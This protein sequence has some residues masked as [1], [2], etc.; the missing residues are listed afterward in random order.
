MCILYNIR[1]PK[2][3]E[4]RNPNNNIVQIRSTF[5]DLIGD[6]SKFQK[7]SF[8]KSIEVKSQG[9]DSDGPIIIS[10][11]N[12]KGISITYD[13]F[14]EVF[15]NILKKVDMYS[16]QGEAHFV[17]QIIFKKNVP[18]NP[19]YNIFTHRNNE[20]VK[21]EEY[22]PHQINSTEKRLPRIQKSIKNNMST[23]RN[24][25]LKATLL[26][27]HDTLI[28][29]ETNKKPLLRFEDLEPLDTSGSLFGTLFPN[30][31]KI[32]SAAD[33]QGHHIGAQGHW[34][35]CDPKCNFFI[36]LANMIFDQATQTIDCPIESC[37]NY[38]HC[39]PF[40]NKMHDIQATYNT[41]DVFKLSNYVC[42]KK[43]YKVCCSSP[44]KSL[45]RTKETVTTPTVIA[46]STFSVEYLDT[47]RPIVLTLNESKIIDTQL[48][49]D[50]RWLPSPKNLE[51]S[52][53]IS[54]QTGFIVGGKQTRIGEF[55][56]T[57]P[58][59]IGNITQ[60]FKIENGN[61][62]RHDQWSFDT[63]LTVGNDIALIRLPQTV[64]TF[65][66]NI[67]MLLQVGG[68]QL[69]IRKKTNTDYAKYGVSQSR[70]IQTNVQFIPKS[71]CRDFRV[72]K[73][74]SDNHICFNGYENSDS[75]EGDSGG[76]VIKLLES[77]MIVQAIVS[78]GTDKCG[79]GIPGNKHENLNNY[80]LKNTFKLCITKL[81]EELIGSKATS[82]A[83][84]FISI[85]SALFNIGGRIW[86]PL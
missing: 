41:K 52:R 76:G 23:I 64:E 58:L 73:S 67:N 13:P 53:D 40:V 74:I 9:N 69:T 70:L 14:V 54:F 10:P 25:P 16:S 46:S 26:S 18:N 56:H 21:K 8:C 31:S 33:S 55:P 43:E 60:R 19:F 50:G 24:S 47:L 27:S 79:K 30:C 42:D 82:K 37:I 61:V 39:S 83:A 2:E 86:F 84:R 78:F 20:S 72:Y 62:I 22:D 44:N 38:N 49:S 4:V 7:E 12:Y 68:K 57:E 34:G 80:K 51:C 71:Q 36:F 29:I 75:C 65:V 66:E 48:S 63:F 45:E 17:P 85:R 15:M 5:W 32:I 6:S 3:F 81:Q 77:Q 11:E 59:L 1:Y 35:N 28:Q